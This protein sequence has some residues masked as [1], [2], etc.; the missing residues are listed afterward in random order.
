MHATTDVIG[1]IDIDT[2][3]FELLLEILCNFDPLEL[4]TSI[5]LVSRR[6]KQAA[7]IVIRQKLYVN[8]HCEVHT[9]QLP[10]SVSIDTPS[11]QKILL[12]T[13]DSDLDDSDVCVWT[14]D[15]ESLRQKWEIMTAIRPELDDP[16]LF[17]FP[18]KIVLVPSPSWLWYRP[19]K[20]TYDKLDKYR[21]RQ[22]LG[23]PVECPWVEASLSATSRFEWDENGG[24]PV[25]Q[26]VTA[27]GTDGLLWTIEYN[28]AGKRQTLLST[29]RLTLSAL[30][31]LSHLYTKRF[32]MYASY[33]IDRFEEDKLAEVQVSRGR[34][35]C[36]MYDKFLGTYIP[37]KDS[38]TNERLDDVS[39]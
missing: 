39:G 1:A 26:R 36:D 38:G 35:F 10:A 18:Q 20:F 12:H 15:S 21:Q 11:P 28:A 5:R 27:E 29:L 17:H 4:C 33:Q 34:E 23:A 30:V 13:L 14:V 6:W 37:L 31:K 25:S 8:S 3:P 32:Q 7:N 19:T 22:I 16:I 2:I 24:R 9:T